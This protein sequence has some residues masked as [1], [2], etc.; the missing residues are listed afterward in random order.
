MCE[1]AISIE[2][3][4]MTKRLSERR[5]RQLLCEILDSAVSGAGRCGTGIGTC[6]WPVLSLEILLISAVQRHHAHLALNNKQKL[7]QRQS[8]PADP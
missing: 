3:A 2:V 8:D 1:F 4:L 5:G 6:R 7:V